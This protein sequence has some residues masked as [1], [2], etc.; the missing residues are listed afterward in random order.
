MKI[1][2]KPEEFYHLI[3]HGPCCLIISGNKKEKNIA[4]I[5]WITPLNDEPPLVIICVATTHYTAEL[6]NKYGEF[7]INV[8]SVE[9]LD[10][11]EFT[12]SI[13]GRKLNK[14]DSLKVTIEDGVKVDVM[15]IKECVGFIEAK[16]VD[17]KEYDGVYLYVGKVLHCEVEKNFYN[18]YLIPYKAKT[19]HHVGGKNFFIS[20]KLLRKIS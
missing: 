11:I 16:V 17:K 19:I 5:A 14:F 6:I 2:I 13:S 20:N 8:P 10:V 7:V 1:K 9:L 15:H 18:K 12:G 4:P 3:N